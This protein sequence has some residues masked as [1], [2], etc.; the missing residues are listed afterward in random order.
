[1]KKRVITIAIIVL[2]IVAIAYKLSVNKKSIDEKSK[3]APVSNVSIP[4]KAMVTSFSEV[5]DALVKT[6]VLVPYREA[7]IMAVSSGKLT[8]VQFV[9]G[10]KVSEGAVIA[11]IDSRGLQLSLEA[12]QLAR[13]KA[14]KDLKRY[15]VLLEGEATTEVTLQ[16][17][18]LSYDNASNQIEQIQKQMTDNKIKAPVSGQ[19]V[20]KTK[21]AGEYVNA[22]TILG[23][24]VDVSR[25]KVDVMVGELD[26][27]TLKAGQQVKVKTDIYPEVVFTGKINFVSNQGDATHNYQV[28]I[29][30][31]NRNDRPLKAGTFVYADFSRESH[32]RLMMIPRSSLVES[33]KNPYVYAIEDGKAV[34]KKIKV[35]REIGDNLEVL[36]GLGEGETIVTAG[37]V[38]I[39][40]GSLVKGI[41]EKD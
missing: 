20:S 24:I 29:E 13:D 6:G 4:V 3:P 38:N 9:L 27:Y 35:G 28:E 11:Q 34:I 41:Q 17:A 32:Q 10:S 36:E 22:G 39:K 18:K 19:V 1:M 5:N 30:L 2:I 31:Q 16:D 26:A 7:D 12:A 8:A 15:T 40:E 37:Q 25:L 21:E 23:H 33:L 14:S